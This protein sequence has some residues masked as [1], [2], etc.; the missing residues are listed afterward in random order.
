VALLDRLPRITVQSAYDRATRTLRLDLAQT[1][2]GEGGCFIL[3]FAF[4]A[5]D[6]HGRELVSKT[7]RFATPD[8]TVTLSD[9]DPPA[10]LSLNRNA[11]FYGTCEDRSATPEQLALQVRLDPDRVNRVEAMRRLTDRERRRLLDDPAAQPSDL[12][13]AT[14]RAI[15]ADDTLPDGI[16]S[17]LLRIEEQPQDRALLPHVREGAVIR[18]RLQRAAAAR[19]PEA[20]FTAILDRPD[21]TLPLPAAIER[22]ALKNALLQLLSVSEAPFAHP[23]LL[24]HFHAATAITARL[25]ALTAL[26]RSG[27]PDRESILLTAGETLRQTLGGKLGYLHVVGQNPR[28]EV[29]E[30]VNR[31]AA[32]PDFDWDHPGMVRALFVPLTLNN[33]QIWSARGLNWLEETAVRLAPRNEY[34]TLRLLAPALGHDRFAPD[35]R[36]AVRATLTRIR[37]RLE[38]AACPWVK[39]RLD[40]A[41]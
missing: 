24:R 12:W 11:G 1:R 3:P 36:E 34:T 13:L 20:A 31:E 30:A 14:W 23:L 32:R 17:Y 15:L 33:D 10:F 18:R 9:I 8:L 22:R 38:S 41:L 5:V 6:A 16:R 40:T 28:E 39:S 35:L 27:H 7:L 19:L 37:A 26:W 2:T 25:N 21:D 29:F 4:A